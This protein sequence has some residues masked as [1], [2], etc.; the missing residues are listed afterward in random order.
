MCPGKNDCI[1][2]KMA[3]GTKER[4]QKR[5]LL[6]NLSEIY[7]SF[8]SENPGMQVGFST[9][10]V[11]RPKW[12]IPVGSAGSH[13]VCVCTYHQNVKLMLSVVN[14]SLDYKNILKLCVCDMSNQNCML[15]HCDDCPDESIVRKFIK[16]QLMLKFT[17]DC[18]IRYKQWVSTDRSELEEK[19]SEIDDFIECLT[20]K[21]FELTESIILFPKSKVNIL[22]RENLP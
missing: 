2:I 8:K 18:S 19:E 7:A 6:A 14:P 10:A 21:L 20:G 16:E 12:C 13:N 15:H 4:V 17:S 5:L 11:L 22:K 9:F 3:D 1:S